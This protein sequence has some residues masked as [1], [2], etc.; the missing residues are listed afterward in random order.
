MLARMRLYRLLC[1]AHFR[2]HRL[3]LGFTTLG[4]AIGVASVVAILTINR[5]TYSSF[6]S[7]VGFLAGKA[8][9]EITNGAAGVP[10]ELLRE[11]EVV[12]GVAAVAG[13]VQEFVRMPSLQGRQ[14]C[15]LGVDLLQQSP[16]WEG[17]FERGGFELERMT[18]A[19][20]EPG[21]VA[22][23]SREVASR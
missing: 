6:Q 17:Q 1:A 19:V 10:E 16:L 23:C 20:K 15:L 5:S 2:R 22:T 14:V 11:I 3:R 12:P 18:D 7:T 21:A 13:T 9:I 8:Q 4:I